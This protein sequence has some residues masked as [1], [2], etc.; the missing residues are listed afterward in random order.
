[1]G[2]Q[3][4]VIRG[5]RQRRGE[6][7]TV[8]ALSQTEQETAMSIKT[9]TVFLA[10]AIALPALTA[11]A[12][13]SSD[14]ASCGNAPRDT[15]MSED[16]VRSHAAEKGYKVRNVKVEDGCYEIYAIDSEGRRVEAYLNPTTGDVV[17]TKLDD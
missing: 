14:E 16:A 4:A 11:S 2:D 5:L 10:A 9:A 7:G 3:A 13:A 1:M 15:W 6:A 8:S 12:F 17:R